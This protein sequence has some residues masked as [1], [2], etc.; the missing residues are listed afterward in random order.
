MF[1]LIFIRK[2]VF[3]MCKHKTSIW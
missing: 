3:Y 1:N 2:Q